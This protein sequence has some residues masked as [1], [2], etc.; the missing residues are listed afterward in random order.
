[1]DDTFNLDRLMQSARSVDGLHDFGAWPF[2][3]A[4]SSL[5]WSL[6]NEA[7]LNDVGRQV[8]QQR[9][10]EIL[11][12]RLRV[13]E[14]LKR[15]P[16]ISEE[17]LL[18]PVFIVGLPRTGTTMLHRTI[19]ADSRFN[20]PLWYEVRFPCPQLDWDFSNE[21]DW[22]I[23]TAKAEVDA[24]LSANP[25]LLS[26][27]P[28]DALGADEDIML[29]EQS[30]F[31]Y[32]PQAF[33]NL[34][35][36]DLWLSEQDHTSGYEYFRLLLKFLQWQK[37][38]AGGAAQRWVLKAPHHLHFM[39]IVLKI[40]P[41]A[42]VVQS[43]RDPIDTIPSLASLIAG[44]WTI[45]SDQVDMAE[46][47][48]QWSSKFASG[49]KKTMEVRETNGDDSFLDL[50]FTDTVKEPLEAVKRVY[51][52]IGLSLTKDA[53]KEIENWQELNRRELRPSHNYTLSQFGLTEEE[54]AEQFQDYREN[55]ILSKKY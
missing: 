19:A 51:N 28:L 10:I 14:W 50:W 20:A 49:M 47:G 13:N 25:D 44:V 29:L 41:D 3:E 1:M 52:F 4:F 27:H 53:K 2:Q 45:Y 5:A 48:R 55:F 42:M 9:L 12:T 11:T 8:M 17:V 38:K 39:D 15:Y 40:F 21:G 54:L 34:P 36:Y 18:P 7:E 37:R 35:A 43:H 16:E 33:A 23:A 26:I 6:A 32:N 22:R 24:M 46:V 31:S 30:F